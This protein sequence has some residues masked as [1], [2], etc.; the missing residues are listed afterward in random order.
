MNYRNRIEKVSGNQIELASIKRRLA[1]FLIDWV[2]VI[3]LYF[4]IIYFFSLFS[5]SD[6]NV[7]VKGI[8]DVDIET[9]NHNPKLSVLLKVIFGL[10]PVL[11]FTLF[12][13]LSKG[14]TPGKFLMRVK[15]VSLFHERI[16]LWHCFERTLGY[17]TSALESG[18]GFIQAAWNPNRMT[19]HDKIGE[20][21]VIKLGNTKKKKVIKGKR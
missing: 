4:L 13:Y 14:R 12:L 2:I 15:V 17:F 5:M 8:F 7:N 21:V 20:T 6:W 3:F 1:A 9:N 10:L 11:Y 16:G 19:L 18:F